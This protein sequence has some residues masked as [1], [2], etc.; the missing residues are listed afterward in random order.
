[1][2]ARNS[3]FTYKGRPVKIQQVAEEL[4]ARHVLEGSVRKA[5]TRVRITAQLI[6]A[7]TGH[8]IW[9]EKF[10]REIEDIFALQDQIT[11]RIAMTLQPELA[12]AEE[13]RSMAK[14]PRDLTAWDYVQRGLSLLSDDLTAENATRAR[15]MYMKAIELDPAYSQAYSALTFAYHIEILLGDPDVAKEARAHLLETGRRAVDLDMADSRAHL[16]LGLARSM[17]VGTIWR[18]RNSGRR[19]NSTRAIP[20]PTCSSEAPSVSW[21]NLARPFRLSR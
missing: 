5:A 4:G 16:A 11:R 21:A 8:H 3:V 10:D 18:S 2:I 1:M 17:R 6:D 12:R 15:Q 9:A 20:L 19:W 14:P 7:A 13:L